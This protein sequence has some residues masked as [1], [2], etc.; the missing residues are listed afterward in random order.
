MMDEF[1]LKFG[2]SAHGKVSIDAELDVVSFERRIS[3]TLPE[4]LR[5]ILVHFGAAVIFQKDVKFKPNERTFLEDSDGYHA[6]EILYGTAQDSNGLENKNATYQDQVPSGLIVLGESPG[7]NQ[8]CLDKSTGRVIFWHHEAVADEES[9][10]E[11]A[12]DFGDFINRLQV[13]NIH[14]ASEPDGIVKEKSF[15]NF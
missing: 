1:E 13:D 14:P 15:L 12:N 5:Q 11:I 7:G 8:V 10:F 3:Y 9:V 4:E 2:A 6:L